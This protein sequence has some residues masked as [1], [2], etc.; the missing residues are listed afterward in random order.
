MKEFPVCARLGLSAHT[1]RGY[2][3]TL[4]TKM[5]VRTQVEAV[6]KA[7]QLGILGPHH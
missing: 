4:Y 2:M 5:G 7:N 6:I 1:C 3:K